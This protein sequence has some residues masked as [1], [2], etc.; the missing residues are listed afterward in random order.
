[1][2]IFQFFRILWARRL[3][4][5]LTFTAAL[6]GGLAIIKLVPH[7]YKATSRV[8]LDIIK[9]DPVSGEAVGSSFARAYT[10]TQAELIRDYRVAGRVVDQLGWTSSS[11]L[12]EEYRRSGSE[13]EFRRW[14]AQRIINNTGTQ[15]V[16]ASNIME[17]SYTSSR[18]ETAALIA[19]AIREA[20][21]EQTMLFKQQAA[22]RNAQWFRR[23]TT[24]LKRQLGEAEAR[25]AEFER[26]N[27]IVLNDNNSDTDTERLA[28]LASAAAAPAISTPGIAVPTTSP[29]QTQLA[30][31]DAAIASA[32]QQLGPNHPDLQNMQRQR[33]VVAQAAARELA[34]LRAAAAASRPTQSG[35]SAASMFSAQRER[36]LSQR[37]KLAEARQLLTDVNVLR[38][39]LQ[40][41]AERAAQLDQESQ[42][43]ET[44]MTRLGSAAAPDAPEFPKTFPVLAGSIALGLG[45]GVLL[46]LL[47][48]LL[49]RRIRSPEDLAIEGIPVIGIVSGEPIQRK[50]SGPLRFLPKP[51]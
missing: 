13:M 45:L 20:Y 38:G 40:R 42:S 27:G 36:V 17:I 22:E 33:A 16:D 7:S 10:R 23:Q 35:P 12:N 32:S 46:A 37:G 49:N 3:I 6:L 9:P 18:P 24:E 34:D 28:A 21:E 4:I 50:L 19:D 30:Q 25:K 47:T 41:T 39:Q 5:I 15:L 14:L 51:S 31:L 29:S 11:Q 48:E 26:A 43:T 8:L 2:S 1:M 44:G